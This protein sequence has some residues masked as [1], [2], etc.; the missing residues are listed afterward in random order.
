MTLKTQWI[1]SFALKTIVCATED[2][3]VTFRNGKAN[4]D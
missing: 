4:E 3:D 1:G 2:R